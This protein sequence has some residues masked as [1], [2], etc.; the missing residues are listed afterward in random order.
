MNTVCGPLRQYLQ[1][2]RKG[3][4]VR[5]PL[6]TYL[7]KVM[8]TER[9]GAE[10]LA[11][12]NKVIVRAANQVEP[13]RTDFN[14]TKEMFEYAKETIIA[15][16]KSE[17]PYEYSV[18]CNLKQN[19]VIGEYTGN[20]NCC[21]MENLESLP[22]DEN[23]IAILHGHP[24]S[25]PISREDVKTLLKYR[26]NQ[27]I[28]IDKDGNFSMVAR[29]TDVAPAAIESKEMKRFTCQCDDNFDAFSRTH[30][31]SLY[32]HM[33]H[34]TLKEEADNLGVRYI[35]NYPYLKE[36]INW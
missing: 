12:Q 34:N 18:I 5:T 14:H 4:V 8:G 16:L 17:E 31:S 36:P 24:G 1:N 33:T 9:K 10:A 29:R 35:T 21:V 7:H 32:K 19:K 13:K 3:I 23:E 22:L 6:R 25:Y 27:V 30:N 11:E 20:G 28:A 2:L 15:P 26:V